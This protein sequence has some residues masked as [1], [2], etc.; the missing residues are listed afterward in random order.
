MIKFMYLEMEGRYGNCVDAFSSYGIRVVIENVGSANSGPFLVDVNGNRL[1]VDNGLKIGES[2]ELH[3]PGTT[4]DGRYEGS[5]DITNLVIEEHED[6]NTFS[7]LAPTP[8]PP[9]LCSPTPSLPTYT[10]LV[11]TDPSIPMSERIVFYYFVM[12]AENPIPEGSV[13]ISSSYILAPT[14]TDMTRGSDTSA[15]LKAALEAVL[16]DSRNGWISDKVEIVDIVIE[17]VHAGIT[18]QGEYFGVGDVTLI[19]A[20]MQILLTTFANPSIDTAVI[21]LNGD[22]I[23][24]LG[25]SNSAEAKPASYVFTR[26]EIEA[27]I[28]NHAYVSR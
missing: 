14:F 23:A 11:F 6:N 27:F 25:I 22:T 20:G 24:N 18:L 26:E 21:T 2:I 4:P 28:H 16:Q 10:P 5:A 17:D 15:D 8:T 19:A 12:P 7:F 13:A 9:P 1:T 3:F